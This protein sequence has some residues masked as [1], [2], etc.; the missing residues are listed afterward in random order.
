LDVYDDTVM[1]YYIPGGTAVG[2]DDEHNNLLL[3][4]EDDASQTSLP[5]S[6]TDSEDA[7]T[8]HDEVQSDKDQ[9][10]EF[11]TEAKVAIRRIVTRWTVP[12][13]MKDT[14][15]EKQLIQDL[16]DYVVGLLEDLDEPIDENVVEDLEAA[17]E[18]SRQ[19]RERVDE[20][21][22]SERAHQLAMLDNMH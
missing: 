14:R 17:T 1:G 2:Q 5:V 15:G 21:R 22:E 18:R 16:V 10:A 7:A 19:I 3:T 11:R 9:I 6:T 8:Q 12:Y 20:E 13:G 4:V